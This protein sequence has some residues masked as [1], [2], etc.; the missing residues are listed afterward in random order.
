MVVFKVPKNPYFVA[1]SENLKYTYLPPTVQC[2]QLLYAGQAISKVKCPQ[3]LQKTNKKI[4]IQSI[5]P[6]DAQD[7]NFLFIFW[8]NWGQHILLSRF[9]DL[10]ILT[11]SYS[12]FL[13]NRKMTST[14]YHCQVSVLCHL[15]HPLILSTKVKMIIL[16][17]ILMMTSTLL[18]IT[19]ATG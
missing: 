10:Q 6:K 11:W 9:S 4:P 8:K 13:Q 7:R 16:M 19:I 1:F 2:L 15:Y 14:A 3:F 17:I 12:F 18:S 5:L